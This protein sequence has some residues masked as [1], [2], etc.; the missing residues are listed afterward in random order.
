MIGIV[1]SCVKLKQFCLSFVIKQTIRV[2]TDLSTK[3]PK[4]ESVGNEAEV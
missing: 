4:D 1:D 2:W 3:I